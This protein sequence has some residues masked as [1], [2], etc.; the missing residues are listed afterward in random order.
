MC[1]APLTTRSILFGAAG[2][3]RDRGWCQFCLQRTDG[4]VCM[5]GAI[6]RFILDNVD[7]ATPQGR[8][9]VEMF[10]GM[11]SMQLLE[12]LYQEHGSLDPV[13]WNDARGRTADEAIAMLERAAMLAA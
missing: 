2:L 3:M 4:R 6:N 10:N 11:A 9:L 8:E 12:A 13:A 1:I 7:G 5:L